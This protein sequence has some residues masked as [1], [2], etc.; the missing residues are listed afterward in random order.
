MTRE[1]DDTSA[2]KTGD[3]DESVSCKTE[4]LYNL[5]IQLVQDEATRNCGKNWNDVKT[6]NVWWYFIPAVR[7][8]FKRFT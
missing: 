1:F 6:N 8:A 4:L 2:D 3:D 5:Y 7:T